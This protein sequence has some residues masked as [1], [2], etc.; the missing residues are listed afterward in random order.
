MRL[1]EFY[2]TLKEEYLNDVLSQMS[3]EEIQEAGKSLEDI[4]K[5]L[6]FSTHEALL[7]FED[8]FWK[9]YLASKVKR[10]G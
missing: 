4:T 1:F 3:M 10:I 2:G 9:G 5:Q 7:V 6:K 8:A